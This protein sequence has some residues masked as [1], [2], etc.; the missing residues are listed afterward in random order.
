MDF[1]KLKN[2]PLCKRS[3]A[4]LNANHL[5]RSSSPLSLA[6]SQTAVAASVI[7]DPLFAK[8]LLPRLQLKDKSHSYPG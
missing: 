8:S 7:Y 2:V 3:S 6:A 4:P 1:P 5:S